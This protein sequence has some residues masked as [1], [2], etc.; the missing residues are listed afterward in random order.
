[1]VN[2]IVMKRDTSI[3]V[4][5]AEGCA[6]L[7]ETPPGRAGG[8]L[9]TVNAHRL[10]EWH[11]LYGRRA[12]DPAQLRELL[13]SDQRVRGGSGQEYSLAWALTYYLWKS[14][15]DEFMNYVQ[16]VTF[17]A[18]GRVYSAEENVEDFEAI[19]GRFDERFI[20]R[21]YAFM[22]DVPRR[23]STIPWERMRG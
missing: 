22:Q 21:W 3:P 5:L 2:T 23:K 20:K 14:Q 19:F 1:M 12:I 13:F 9:G 8:G 7:F 10:E 6:M 16:M 15:R 18:P 17:R 11:G 4:W